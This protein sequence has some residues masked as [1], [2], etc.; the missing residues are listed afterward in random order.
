M[1]VYKAAVILACCP[2]KPVLPFSSF[3]Y[4]T[5]RNPLELYSIIKQECWLTPFC[6]VSLTTG[7]ASALS[8]LRHQEV[9]LSERFLRVIVVYV[10]QAG[11]AFIPN[12]ILTSKKMMI[13]EEQI[14]QCYLINGAMV[15]GRCQKLSMVCLHIN[16]AI[17]ARGIRVTWLHCGTRKQHLSNI[18]IVSSVGTSFIRV[19]SMQC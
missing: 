16:K 4:H 6:A 12:N 9:K 17:V 8:T 2:H 14:T 19:Y 3:V 11:H 18:F 5:S 7:L 13:N 10:V 1:S 15:Q